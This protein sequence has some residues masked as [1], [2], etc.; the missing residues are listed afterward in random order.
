MGISNLCRCTCSTCAVAQ[1]FFKKHPFVC[2]MLVD[3]PQ[4]VLAGGQNKRLAQLP[5][6]LER[7]QMVQIGRGLLS[8]DHRAAAAAARI[9]VRLLASRLLLGCNPRTAAGG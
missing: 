1:D 9:A 4:A 3:D 8:F 6:R 7:A 2:N 5:Q